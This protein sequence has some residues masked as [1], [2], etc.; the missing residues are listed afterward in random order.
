MSQSQVTQSHDTEKGIE[1]SG[2]N[3]IIQY[4]NNMLVL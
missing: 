4:S 2:I 1:D 3:N